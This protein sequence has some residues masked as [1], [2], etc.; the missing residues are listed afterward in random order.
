MSA[1]VISLP[2]RGP[3]LLTKKQL[4]ARLGRSQRWVELRVHDGMP[5]EPGSD[6]H[7]RRRY[8]LHHVEQWLRD[9]PANRST[10]QDRLGKLEQTVAELAAQVAELRQT[11]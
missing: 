7:G 5:V 1:Q 6:R 8:D 3:V 9:R 10:R 4:A 11:G 2:S